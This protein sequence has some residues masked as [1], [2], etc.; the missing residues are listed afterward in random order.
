LLR[1]EDEYV[2]WCLDEAVAEVIARLESKQKLKP[3]KTQD[4]LALLERLKIGGEML[5]H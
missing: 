1:I 5:G 4:N 3:K 2:A